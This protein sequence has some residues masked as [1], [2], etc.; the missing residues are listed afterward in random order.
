MGRS[1][2]YSSYRKLGVWNI[3]FILYL[4]MMAEAFLGY[5]LPWHQMSYWAAT[6][7]TSILT[8]IPIVG[9]SISLEGGFLLQM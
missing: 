9:G 4:L 1:L 2:Y 8:S 6:V 3:G 5:I 7:I